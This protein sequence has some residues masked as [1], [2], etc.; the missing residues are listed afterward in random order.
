MGEKGILSPFTV[1]TSVLTGS[2]FPLLGSFFAIIFTGHVYWEG[3]ILTAFGGFMAHYF[4][5]HTIHD[6]VHSKIEKR[7]TMSKR[8][9]KILLAVT[10][11]ILLSIA[12][13]LS[14]KC[15]WPVLVFSIIGAIVCMYAE[16][17][18][19]HESQMAFG[20][21]FL[22]IGSFY[23]Q[24]GYPDGVSSALSLGAKPWIELI[25]LSLFAFFSQYGWLLFY[26]LDDY[27]WSKEVKNR[28]IILTKLG[29]VFL[30]MVFALH[31]LM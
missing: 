4:L 19:H 18:L 1:V 23:V 5:A 16:G 30:V 14:I 29:L 27:N 8:T 3:V 25:F 20:A 13:Y 28:S 17:L 12:I 9:L 6:L 10:L 11:V 24:A 26:R 15:G 2:F 7:V 31:T 22:V 21:M